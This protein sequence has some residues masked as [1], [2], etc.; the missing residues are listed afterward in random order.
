M[1]GS[2]AKSF[3]FVLFKRR[4][5]GPAPFRNSSDKLRA[6]PIMIK[7]PLHESFAPAWDAQAHTSVKRDVPTL[8]P[9]DVAAASAS[10]AGL[11]FR[12]FIIAQRADSPGTAA[13]TDTRMDTPS[14]SCR[15]PRILHSNE[16]GIPS[17]AHLGVYASHE[18]YA[19]ALPL[20]FAEC[21]TDLCGNETNRLRRRIL[22][23]CKRQRFL[24]QYWL[25]Q[26]SRQFSSA[27]GGAS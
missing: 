25:K 1:T 26:I 8:F 20:L 2:T 18:R 23:Q 11:R 9:T 21:P 5:A 4:Q 16:L 15:P 24:T 12:P 6:T 22:E 27:R 10:A 19:G 17:H 14:T 7:P 13:H 3:G